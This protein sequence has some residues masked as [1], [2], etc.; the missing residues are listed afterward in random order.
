[1]AGE[2]KQPATVLVSTLKERL[3]QEV[4]K[5]AHTLVYLVGELQPLINQDTLEIGYSPERL[6]LNLD[7]IETQAQRILNTVT[8]LRTIQGVEE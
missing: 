2:K 4:G 8:T 6:E 3:L 5:R 1:M 7:D